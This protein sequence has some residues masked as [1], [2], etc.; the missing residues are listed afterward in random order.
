MRWIEDLEGGTKR[1][2]RKCNLILAISNFSVVPRRHV[3]KVC[4][5]RNF[6]L[7]KKAEISRSWQQ[8]LMRRLQW[9]AIQIYRTGHR[10]RVEDITHLPKSVVQGD[11]NARIVPIDY[12]SCLSVYNAFIVPETVGQILR[13]IATSMQDR[14]LYSHILAFYYEDAKKPIELVMG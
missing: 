5:N 1:K 7:Q 4:R 14:A 6:S 3:C 8:I 12:R 10:L 13:K 9:D 2:C 11:T